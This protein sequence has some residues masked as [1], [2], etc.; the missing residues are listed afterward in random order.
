M[1]LLEQAI[2]A[3]APEERHY[4]HSVRADD[5]NGECITGFAS[6]VKVGQLPGY[7]WCFVRLLGMSQHNAE[8]GHIQTSRLQELR[9]PITEAEIAALEEATRLQL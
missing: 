8:Y 1:F 5:S 7:S 9:R 3:S 2:P 6:E 4:T